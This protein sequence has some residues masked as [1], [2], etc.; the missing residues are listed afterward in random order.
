[1]LPQSVV[2]RLYRQYISK[3]SLGYDW[4]QFCKVPLFVGLFPGN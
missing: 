4:I 1:M 3:T 2:F